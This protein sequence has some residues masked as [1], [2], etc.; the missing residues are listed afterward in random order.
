MSMLGDEKKDTTGDSH[1]LSGLPSEENKMTASR[2]QVR[3]C[4]QCSTW[5]DAPRTNAGPGTSEAAG[6]SGHHGLHGRHGH[7]DSHSGQNSGHTVHITINNSFLLGTISLH[8][9]DNGS[10]SADSGGHIINLYD[11]GGAGSSRALTE[12]ERNPSGCNPFDCTPSDRTEDDDLA[13]EDME[14]SDTVWPGYWSRGP[15]NSDWV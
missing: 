12:P 3:N 14:I 1:I 6:I 9:R 15:L 13:A 8:Y 11:A 5:G 10:R 2:G 7:D 4:D